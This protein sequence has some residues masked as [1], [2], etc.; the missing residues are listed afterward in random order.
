MET[1]KIKAILYTA[2]T[3][4]DGTHPIM[5]R[6]TQNRQR[7]YKSVGHSV[8]PDSWDEE[9]CC[10]Y[11]KEPK[12]T[13]RQEGQL[14]PEKLAELKERYK[15]SIV[16]PN[17]S[18]INS[19]IHDMLDE[20]AG[21]KDD[22]KINKENLDLKTIKNK[23][24][25]NESVDRNKSFTAY[26][27]AHR[28][29]FLKAGSIGTY[30][31]YKST[32]NK[33]EKYLKG[34]DLLFA[35]LTVHFLEDYS[36]YMQKNES[37]KN[38][39]NKRLK[40][41]TIH[42]HFKC[43]RSIYYAAIAEQVITADKNPFFVYKLKLDKNVRKDKLTVEEIIAIENLNLKE[44]SLIWDARNFFLFSFYCAGIRASDVLMLKWQNINKQDRLEYKMDKTGHH[45]SISL[46]PK[47]KDIL[48]KYKPAKPLPNSFIF[49]FMDASL[50]LT[51]VMTLFNHISSNVALVNK[52]LKE[53]AKEAKIEKVLSTHIARHS[54]ADIART[55]KASVYDISKM[56]GHSS[57]KVT[58]AYLAS[59]DVDSQDEAMKSIM[60]F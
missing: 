25:P 17:A 2:K 34:K 4:K 49:P 28:D 5:I 9:N 40:T 50:D 31:S 60:D 35:D 30:K 6:I 36:V 59:F 57:I 3:Y 45:K 55:R 43:I 19:D 1:T 54:F 37:K 52:Y 38:I 21:I 41:N 33:L 10:V 15:H 22:I 46:I 58:E 11:E 27:E 16:L 24:N 29:K 26:G 39:T 53:V 56:L 20:L 13:K 8:V 51:D 7:I 23:L 44:N 14:K 48:K 18:S 42:K 47:A 32:L 12:I